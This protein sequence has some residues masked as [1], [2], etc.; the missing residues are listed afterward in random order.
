MPTRSP[1]GDI[2][3]PPAPTYFGALPSST[4]SFDSHAEE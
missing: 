4:R 3:A 2:C 1:E